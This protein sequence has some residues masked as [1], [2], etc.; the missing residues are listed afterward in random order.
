M[1]ICAI[2]GLV[3]VM[4]AEIVNSKRYV[5]RVMR[6]APISG[7]YNLIDLLVSM[8]YVICYMNATYV[9]RISSVVRCKASVGCYVLHAEVMLVW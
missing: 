6:E 1:I 2:S 7:G 5:L 4:R 8:V 9:R 3:L